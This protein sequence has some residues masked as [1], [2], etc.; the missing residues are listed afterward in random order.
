LD[1]AGYVFFFPSL[2]VGPAFDFAEYKRWV[3]TTMFDL[4]AGVDPSKKPPSRNKRRI[5]RSGTPAALKAA[6]GLCWIGL[7]VLL[8]RWFYPTILLSNTFGEMAFARR[9]LTT[10]LVGLTA[11]LKF[12][13]VWTLSESACILAGL[14]YRGVDP[15][16][17]KVSWDRLQNIKPWVVETAQNS[18]GFLEGWNINTNHWLRNYVYLRVTPRGNKPGFRAS[19]ATFTASAIWHGFYPGY[20]LTFILASLIQTVAKS[21]WLHKYPH[22]HFRMS[23]L[24]RQKP[25]ATSGLSSLIPRRVSLRLP[26][27]ITTLYPGS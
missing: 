13:S 17:G 24:P 27:S 1:F 16:T 26:R 15:L 23:D 3:D 7:F 22:A 19:L 5:P 14:G 25:A 8:S 9:V 6:G 12:Y 2:M 18:R 10:Y 11:R 20:Y 4:P 21:T